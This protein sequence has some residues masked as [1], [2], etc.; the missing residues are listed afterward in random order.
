MSSALPRQY[1]R[2]GDQQVE[3]PDGVT[4]T[5]WSLERLRAQNPRIRAYLGSLR[6]LEDTL[7][8][9][10][11]ILHCSPGRLL[12]IWRKVRQ[13]CRLLQT[14][15]LPALEEP[16]VIPSLDT[17]RRNAVYSYHALHNTVITKLEKY[18]YRI[19]PDQAP[20][21][22]R[23]LCVSIGKIYAF[24]RD[25]F[26]EIVAHDPRGLHDSDYYLSRR[27]PQDIEEAEWLYATVDRLNE[28]LQGLGELWARQ[29]KHLTEQMESERLLLSRKSWEEVDA[30][31]SILIDGLSPKLKEVLTLSGIRY[32]E[33]EPLD[34]YAFEIP[35]YARL[36]L[37]VYQ[38][39]RKT[40]D[41]LKA[42]SA[43]SLEA[44]HQ[45]LEDILACHAMACS[46]LTELM[47]TI[48]QAI[49][50]LLA[51]VPL[52]LDSIEKRRALMLTKNPDEIP[53]RPV[54]P[55]RSRR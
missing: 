28:Y 49:Q 38:I 4:V 47:T 11:A 5:D 9:N 41:R 37:E 33:M 44:R 55:P 50:D 15:L 13:V 20:A 3:L 52:W 23:L 16:S 24:L 34:E 19:E 12:Q 35:H 46:R 30:F 32:D 36:I 14:K 21:V 6:L 51:Y 39:S 45:H 31:M 1:I 43:E 53:I 17:A 40:I 54:R 18:P 48:E 2:V 7:E 42:R 8:S 27:F 29:L 22:R 10:Y 25:T 26:G